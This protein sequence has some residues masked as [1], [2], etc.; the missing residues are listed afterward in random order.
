[1]GLLRYTLIKIIHTLPIFAGVTFIS[2]LLM[3]YFGSDVTHAL[4]GKNA[5]VGDLE[6][7]RHQLGYDLGLFERYFHYLKELLTFDFGRSSL[8]HEKVSDIFRRS[9]PI[10]L[11]LNL[12]GFILGNILAVVLSL[13]AAYKR[14]QIFDKVIM[15]FSSLGMS[16][17]FL[18]VILFFQVLFCSSYGW[19]LFPVQGWDMS[20]PRAYLQYVFVP[21]L[22]SIFVSLGYN[23]RFFRALIVEEMNKYH[24]Q[25]AVSL[26]WSPFYIMSKGVLRNVLVSMLTRVMFSI[27][28]IFME[29]SV[30]IES[31]FG[32][33]GMGR[34]AFNA[35]SSGDLPVLKALV[36]VGTLVYVCIL[37]LADL[38]YKIVD[39]R[40]NL[41]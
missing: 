28:F 26:G 25:L 17:S 9:I 30:L 36:G 27:P 13:F 14:G 39:P 12:P 22:A 29:G 40:V 18:I 3:V 1:M 7:L 37:I 35:V 8:T 11:A 10:S 31:F 19:D 38:V 6:Q 33:P 32:I 23:T 20:S 15:F 5:T 16:M 21:T 41:S 24:V 34:V 2:F 4:V